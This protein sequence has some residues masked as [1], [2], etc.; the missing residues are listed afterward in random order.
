V[1]LR[2]ARRNTAVDKPVQTGIGGPADE[3]T[4][5]EADVDVVARLAGVLAVGEGVRLRAAM[6]PVAAARREGT[7]LPTREDHLRRIV[8]LAGRHDHVLVEGAGGV[9]VEL[10]EDGTTQADL[11]TGLLGLFGLLGAGQVGAVVVCRAGLGALNHTALTVEALERRRVPVTG[12]VIGSWPADPDEIDLDNRQHLASRTVPLLGAVPAGAGGL[13][14]PDFRRAAPG[15][16][17]A[18]PPPGA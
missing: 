15:R 3:P 12:L 14:G 11:G 5:D 6:A 13:A 16:L 18:P 9:L 8:R 2:Q 10:A 1:D 7:T 17:P 4:G